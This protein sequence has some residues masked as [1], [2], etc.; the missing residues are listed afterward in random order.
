MKRKFDEVYDLYA[1]LLY[2]IAYTYMK[3]KEDSE[4][5]VQDVFLKWF[6][7]L[8]FQSQEHEKAW[9]IVCCKNICKNNLKKWW[10][11]QN[12]NEIDIYYRENQK[13]DFYYISML[14]ENLKIITYLYYYEGYSSVEIGK[15]L[16]KSDSTIRSQLQL[17]KDKMKKMIEGEN[18]E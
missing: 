4:D 7:H 10:K 18:D 5:V 12:T 16:K 14:P 2:R 13:D 17:A 9:L 8:S 1:P 6:H 3:N 15:I 11:Q